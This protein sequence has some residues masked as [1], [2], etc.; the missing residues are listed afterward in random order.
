MHRDEFGPAEA[1]EALLVNRAICR[2]GD[3]FGKLY[4]R[5]VDR[6]YRHIYYRVGNVPDTED[7]TQRVFLKAW[8]AVDRYKRTRSPFLAWLM[9]IT[10]NVVIDFYRTAKDK[11]YV[12]TELLA[13]E[14][15]PSADQVAE[16]R[17]E[18]Q[19]MRK[20]ILQLP[21]DQQQVVLMRFVEGFSYSEV[22]ASLGKR[23]GAVRV[24]LHR[25]LARL[26][27]MLQ[28]EKG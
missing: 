7:L 26:R 17:F 10:H 1:N 28:E 27:H 14:S 5:H 22:A 16:S 15:S 8:E 24:I 9:T 3:A 2:D 4:D 13:D 12:E 25:A 20:A 19:R 18:Q 21:S 6:V 11:A 23:E